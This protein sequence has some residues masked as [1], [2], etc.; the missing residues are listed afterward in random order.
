MHNIQASIKKHLE[1]QTGFKC[2][3]LYDGVKVPTERPILTIEALPTI[4]GTQ[5]KLKDVVATKTRYQIGVLSKTG[6]QAA[7]L[8]H[9]IADLLTFEPVPL[10][11]TANGGAVVGELDLTVTGVTPLP[12][13]EANAEQKHKSYIDVAVARTFGR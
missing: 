8:P 5:A 9:E 2:I 3:W 13:D 10:L 1:Q 12:T 4:Y 6:S 7:Q 11:D